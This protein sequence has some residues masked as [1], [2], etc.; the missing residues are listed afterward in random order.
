MQD[1]PAPIVT[2]YELQLALAPE[3]EW[4]GRYVLD[5]ETLLTEGVVDSNKVATTK[6]EGDHVDEEEDTPHFSLIT[7]KY[8]SSKRPAV[9]SGSERTFICHP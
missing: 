7:G 5:F 6:E 3:P 8:H 2:P 1:F 4:T 9:A